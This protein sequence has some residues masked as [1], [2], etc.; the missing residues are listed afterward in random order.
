MSMKSESTPVVMIVSAD[1][2]AAS[3]SWS[4]YCPEWCVTKPLNCTRCPA[5]LTLQPCMEDF[6]L[7]FIALCGWRSSA[8]RRETL[9]AKLGIGYILVLWSLTLTIVTNGRPFCNLGGGSCS[10]VTDCLKWAVALLQLWLSMTTASLMGKWPNRRV[11]NKIGRSYPHRFI[12][13]T[14]TICFLIIYLLWE[15]SCSKPF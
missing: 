12:E 14:T 8:S 11:N 10:R 5:Q 2:E 15:C 1:E 7:S 9:R 6:E 3:R 4:R 13:L